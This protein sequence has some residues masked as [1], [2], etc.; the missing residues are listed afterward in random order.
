MHQCDKEVLINLT[1][2]PSAL[3]DE[4][5]HKASHRYGEIMDIVFPAIDE[6][7]DESYIAKLADEYLEKILII[8]NDK[9][10]TVHLMGE[11]TFTF[12]LLKRLRAQGIPCIAS[13]TKRIVKEETAGKK[14]EVIFQFE[15]FRHYE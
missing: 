13:T 3:W 8:A 12:A 6:T 2:H 7:G 4:K 9:N 15:R 10:I 1:N 5:Q 11:Q 14:K